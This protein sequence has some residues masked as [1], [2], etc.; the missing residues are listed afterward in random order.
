MYVESARSKQVR[1]ARRSTKLLEFARPENG[2]RIVPHLVLDPVP[3]E[4]ASWVG[5]YLEMADHAL[6]NHDLPN[7]AARPGGPNKVTREGV[8]VGT[9]IGTRGPMRRQA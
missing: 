7:P 1:R 9:G 2:H 8:R 4:E 6:N 3:P 5:K